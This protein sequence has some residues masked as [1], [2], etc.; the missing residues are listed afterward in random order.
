MT[1][2]LHQA[3]NF[4]DE[5]FDFSKEGEGF[6]Q[7][8]YPDTVKKNLPTVGY[9]YTFVIDQGG[10]NWAIRNT[11]EADFAA[12]GVLLGPAEMKLLDA[13]VK[14]MNQ[15]NDAQ[16][17][18]D[19]AALASL[20]RP[21]SEDEGRILFNFVYSEN[22]E[23][24]RKTFVRR[25]GLNRGQA[26]YDS[27]VGTREFVALGDMAYNTPKLIG[28]KLID[29]LVAG[30]RFEAWFQIRYKSNA[31]RVPGL[32]SR[33]YKEADKFGLYNE[34]NLPQLSEEEATRV[35]RGFTRNHAEIIRYEIDFPP[36]RA[37]N[38][39]QSLSAK[40][41]LRFADQKL[42]D[43]YVKP[44]YNALI[45]AGVGAVQVGTD[46]AD[47]LRGWLNDAGQ[48]QDDLIIGGDGFD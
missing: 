18:K 4:S 7:N 21:I 19:V 16:T 5:A 9:G 43:T 33:R 15:G 42:I 30:D 2:N 17:K 24:M 26:L 23:L 1:L 25:L 46:G 36:N 20:V 48:E 3:S 44:E 31:N 13:I 34:D 45:Q 38:N 40:E 22:L 29:A 41:W 6:Y 11:V 35:L 8:I 47:E 28:E 37:A 32:A 39:Y 27:L 12:F 10:G 14:D